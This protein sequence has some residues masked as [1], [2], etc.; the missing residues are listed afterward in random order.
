MIEDLPTPFILIEEA[1][2]LRNVGRMA[3]YARSH[4]LALRPHTKTH[5]STRFAKLQLDHGAVG[6]TVAKTGEAQVMAPVCNDLLMAYPAVNPR[7]CAD[8]AQLAKSRMLRV[9]VD[10]T[11]AADALSNA[12]RSA[13]GTIAILVDLDVGHH[14]TGV[15]SPAEALALAQ[16]ISRQPGLHLDGL[17]FF[18]GHL[19]HGSGSANE[20]G[21]RAIESLLTETL[22]LWKTHGLGAGIVSG[23]STPT[24]AQS[25]LISLMTEF[26]PGTYI[27]NDINSV[28]SGCCTFED[29]AAKIIATVVSTAVPGQVVLDAGSKTLTSDRC[30]PAPDSGHGYVVEYPQARIT[31]LSEEHAQVDISGCDRAPRVGERV[32]IIPNHICPCVNLQDF[33]WVRTT[34]GEEQV[35]VEARGKVY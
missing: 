7:R 14:R 9:A 23:G 10:S 22:D 6:L 33:V 2:V 17:M 15:Q 1:V 19:S 27:F 35:P 29:C 30:G 26:R 3:D 4:H 8:L 31:K 20:P 34:D 13:G 21:L 25:H 18:P 11:F 5:K 32:S 24:A 28:R 12:A 16:H